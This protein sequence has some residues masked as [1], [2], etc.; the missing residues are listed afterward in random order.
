MLGKTPSL[1]FFKISASS[2]KTIG[3]N[4]GLELGT[5]TIDAQLTDAVKQELNLLRRNCVTGS[6]LLKNLTRL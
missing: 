3:M 2:Y 4:K 5:D 1:N 6:D